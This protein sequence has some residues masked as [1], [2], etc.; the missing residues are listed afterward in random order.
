MKS[1]P[2]GQQNELVLSSRQI[3]SQT[4]EVV[5]RHKEKSKQAENVDCKY[6]VQERSSLETI[7]MMQIYDAYSISQ[8]ISMLQDELIT[9]HLRFFDSKDYT[10]MFNRLQID[11]ASPTSLQV[12]HKDDDRMFW[13][14]SIPLEFV[15]E[16][17]NPKK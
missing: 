12:K 11:S 16:L 1:K 17:I 2:M 14:E 3:E 4:S 5:Y 13:R 7:D 8:L 9:D 10:S 15:D 6:R